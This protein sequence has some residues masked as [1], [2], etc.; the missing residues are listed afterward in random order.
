MLLSRYENLTMEEKQRGN[1][2][3]GDSNE[4]FSAS[5]CDAI[6]VKLKMEKIEKKGTKF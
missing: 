6:K 2:P 5:D 3:S 1:E 4:S